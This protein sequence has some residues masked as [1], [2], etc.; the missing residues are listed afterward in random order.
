MDNATSLPRYVPSVCAS[1][2]WEIKLDD[3]AVNMSVSARPDAIVT[4]AT[5]RAGGPVVG[6]VLGPHMEMTPVAKVD[7]D[8]AFSTVTA[9]YEGGRLTSTAVADQTVLLHTLDDNLTN[10]QYAAKLPGRFVADRTFF[11][12]E[13]T[14]GR[15]TFAAAPYGSNG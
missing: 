5:P 6:L 4:L 2:S 13:A 15:P 11:H 9:S 7:I 14:A 12:T 3:I 10:P 1:Q 8:G